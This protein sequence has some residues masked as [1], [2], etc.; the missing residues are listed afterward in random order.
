M[1][2]PSQVTCAIYTNNFYLTRAIIICYE[3][4][5]NQV[6]TGWLI[7]NT[8][9]GFDFLEYF[10][11]C[12]SLHSSQRSAGAQ[13]AGK[14]QRWDSGPG[15]KTARRQLRARCSKAAAGTSTLPSEQRHKMRRQF[16]VFVLEW[17]QHLFQTS[18]LPTTN[19]FLIK[20]HWGKF[21]C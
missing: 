10:P 8:K 3:W 4:V 1:R 15:E 11:S 16:T 17:L 19:E 14:A 7:L 13:A 21:L 2:V 6:R 9:Q 20:A 5:R 12:T 18:F